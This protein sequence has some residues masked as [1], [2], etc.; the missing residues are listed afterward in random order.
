[1]IVWLKLSL[2]VAMVGG[3]IWTIGWLSTFWI[4]KWDPYYN[5][6]GKFYRNLWSVSGAMFWVGCISTIWWGVVRL[7]IE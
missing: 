6:T 1:M 3:L 7:W 5:T 4:T 2:T